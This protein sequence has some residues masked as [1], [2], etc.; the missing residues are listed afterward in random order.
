MT[1]FQ[2]SKTDDEF[3]DEILGELKKRVLILITSS[4]VVVAVAFGV[5]FYFAFIATGS[6]MSR[7]APEL[8]PIVSKLK[9]LLLFNTFGVIGII[10]LSLY[11]FN[12]ITTSKY[13]DTLIQIRRKMKEIAHGPLPSKSDLNTKGPFGET[14][15][16]F[17]F[18]LSKIEEKEARELEKLEEI[19]GYLESED[20]I[21]LET[22]INN[23]INRK[24]NYLS[25]RKEAE[26]IQG[27][28]SSNS[29]DRVFLQR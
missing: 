9:D 14:E 23:L 4:T 7:Q 8:L 25:G 19:N 12:R 21:N 29:S 15:S 11:I 24:R 5:S 6:A 16:S 2:N 10:L 17:R 20:Y 1:G 13:F 26:K 28:V 22:S 3:A 18:M 27:K